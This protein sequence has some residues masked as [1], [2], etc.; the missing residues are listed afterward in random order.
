LKNNKNLR[1]NFDRNPF[2]IFL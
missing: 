2:W 1:Y